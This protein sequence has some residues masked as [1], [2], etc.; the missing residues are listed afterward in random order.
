MRI[1]KAAK[2]LTC[3]LK[4]HFPLASSYHFLYG[5]LSVFLLYHGFSLEPVFNAHREFVMIV[6]L[7][8]LLPLI[9]IPRF[10]G[11]NYSV[12]GGN[13]MVLGMFTAL[14]AAACFGWLEIYYALFAIFFGL[15]GILI[16]T[17][18]K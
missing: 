1:R 7:I 15:G 8:S 10:C 12:G 17:F 9:L 16:L 14:M 11:K 2:K 18:K 13:W 4:S 6:A 3:F 5:V